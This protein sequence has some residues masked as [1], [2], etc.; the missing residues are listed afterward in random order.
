MLAVSNGRLI[1]LSTPYGKRGFIF[2]A[3]WGTLDR[4]GILWLTGEHYQRQ[5]PL[6]NVARHL[7]CD[8]TWYA[9]PSGANQRCQPRCADFLVM[10]GNNAIRPGI[11][12]VSARL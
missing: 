11:A 10:A 3:V 7:P 2:D 5:Q 1:C 8:V 4:D 12:A 6:S 9:Y